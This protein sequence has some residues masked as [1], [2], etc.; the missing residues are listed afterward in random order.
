MKESVAHLWDDV[1]A[2]DVGLAEVAA[3]FDGEDALRSVMRGVLEKAR[4]ELS[5]MHERLS[6]KEAVENTVPGDESM[7]LARTYFNKGI[8]LYRSI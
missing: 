4:D 8:Q 3:E 5:I 7:E 6:G 2:I 1:N